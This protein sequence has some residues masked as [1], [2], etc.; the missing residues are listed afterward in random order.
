MGGFMG[1]K[2]VLLFF[3]LF[4]CIE[5]DIKLS[6][7]NSSDSLDRFIQLSGNNVRSIN[8]NYLIDIYAGNK[9]DNIAGLQFETIGKDFSLVRAS[10]GLAEASGFNF[11]P[12]SGG[13]ILAFSLEGKIISANTV[14][15]PLI[16]LEVK[17]HTKKSADL[18]LKTIIAGEKGVK[19]ESIFSPLN[20]K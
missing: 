5:S 15:K 7:T 12:G 2:K 10:G 13:V 8:D 4:V 19:L 16:T 14:N 18:K 3:S 11:Y 17:K 1:F 6:K 20:L 9:F